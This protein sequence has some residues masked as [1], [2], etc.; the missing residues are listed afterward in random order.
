MCAH[1]SSRA[2]HVSRGG[3][4]AGIDDIGNVPTGVILADATCVITSVHPQVKMHS[5]KYT[6]KQVGFHSIC[7][8]ES[9]ANA[10][11]NGTCTWGFNF[12]LF[13]KVP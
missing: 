8:S 3:R 5:D 4:K 7:T 13:R 6:V 10:Y 12:C 2:S 11:L 1:A 9:R